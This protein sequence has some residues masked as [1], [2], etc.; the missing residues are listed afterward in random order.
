M[1]TCQPVDGPNRLGPSFALRELWIASIL[2]KHRRA[3]Q[4]FSTMNLLFITLYQFLFAR[5]RQGSISITCPTKPFRTHGIRGKV[6]I[7]SRSFRILSRLPG[8]LT[9][10]LAGGCLG[11]F[12]SCVISRTLVWSSSRGIRSKTSDMKTAARSA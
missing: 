9:V 4:L 1:S 5:N 8:Y 2:I 10:Q 12:W 11:F 3:N 6:W 7:S